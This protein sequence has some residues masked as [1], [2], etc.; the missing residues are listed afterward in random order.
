MQKINSTGKN[1]EVLEKGFG[2]E[3]TAEKCEE[4]TK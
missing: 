1:E 3:I 2:K 4:K